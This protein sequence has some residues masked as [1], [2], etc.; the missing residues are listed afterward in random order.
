MPTY[1][2]TIGDNTEYID[3]ETRSKARWQGVRHC[4]EWMDRRDRKRMFNGVIVRRVEPYLGPP[5]PTPQQAADAWNAQHP[6]GTVVRYWRGLREGPPS[7]SGKTRAAAA[8]ISGHVSVWIENCTGCISISH[9][10]AAPLQGDGGPWHD[11][12]TD[13]PNSGSTLRL[14]VDVIADNHV[15]QATTNTLCYQGGPL[16]WWRLSTWVANE[17]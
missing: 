10:E 6:I 13:P 4:L 14:S 16:P 9:V 11:L 3:A 1:A 8:V 2:V 15:W 17:N 7:G 12:A 5:E